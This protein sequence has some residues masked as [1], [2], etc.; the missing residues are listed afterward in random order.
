MIFVSRTLQVAD[1]TF[2]LIRY[3]MERRAKLAK[4]GASRNFDAL[5]EIASRNAKRSGSQ[6]A[7]WTG[8]LLSKIESDQQG[9][10][11][12]Q[13]TYVKRLFSHVADRRQRGRFVLN[14]DH[15]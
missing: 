6:F 10:G 12:G 11:C 3:L 9:Q 7:H 5:R 4:L 13:Q 8:Q 14:R 15:A 1:K 2:P